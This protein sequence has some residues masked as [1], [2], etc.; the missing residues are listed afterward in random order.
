MLQKNEKNKRYSKN[1]PLD[2]FTDRLVAAIA[3][4]PTLIRLKDGD[5]SANVG[6]NIKLGGKVLIGDNERESG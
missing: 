5:F 6:S 3:V 1:V 2:G 4:K